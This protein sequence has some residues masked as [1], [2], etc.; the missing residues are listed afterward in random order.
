MCLAVPMTIISING[1]RAIAEA[2]G[3]RRAVDITMVPDVRID[4]KVI[5]HAGFVLERL[6][7]DEAREIE[8]AWDEY[9][10][11]MDDEGGPGKGPHG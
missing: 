9:K 7:P 6:N 3:V 11:I 8:A 10:K 1:T 2:Y 4:D 5:I